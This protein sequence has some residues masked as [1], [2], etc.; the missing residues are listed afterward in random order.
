MQKTLNGLAA[1]AFA[2]SGAA[3]ASAPA[4]A[5]TVFEV[6]HARATARAGRLVSEHDDELL[7]RYGATSGTGD[8][9][10]GETL[11]YYFDDHP[12]RHH[13][14]GHHRHHWR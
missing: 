8:Y 13:R 4:S 1:A 7:Q 10:R 2:L 5:D 9:R 6:E 14:R 3:A 12:V 11:T